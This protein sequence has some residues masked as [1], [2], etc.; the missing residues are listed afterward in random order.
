MKSKQRAVAL[1]RSIA[2]SETMEE[3]HLNVRNLKSSEFW[4]RKSSEPLRT[5]LKRQGYL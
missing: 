3:Y 1:L 2:M 4:R 5:G